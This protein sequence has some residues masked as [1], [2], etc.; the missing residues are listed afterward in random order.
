MQP[1]TEESGV[2]LSL[3]INNIN[4]L[5]RPFIRLRQTQDDSKKWHQRLITLGRAFGVSH[6]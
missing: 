2:G 4:P 6:R 3:S 1:E 5:P